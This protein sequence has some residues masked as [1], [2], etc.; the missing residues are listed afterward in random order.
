MHL[1][2]R[3]SGLLGPTPRSLDPSLLYSWTQLRRLLHTVSLLP[4]PPSNCR[5]RSSSNASCAAVPQPTDTA[6]IYYSPSSTSRTSERH[7]GTTAPRARLQSA[8]QP[9]PGLENY[10]QLCASH[11]IPVKA[12]PVRPRLRTSTSVPSLQ[13]HVCTTH[14][15]TPP[16]R[17]SATYKRSASTAL[18]GTNHA[19][20][21]DSRAG[22]GPFPKPRALVLPRV[23]FGQ[24][25]PDGLGHIDTADSDLMHRQ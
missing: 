4:M 17:L 3:H 9:P 13:P 14:V 16:V 11:G 20:G 15:G 21:A 8:P 24:A 5:S 10:A 25:T 22:R 23:K 7:E 12:A 19:I 18:A 6:T 1:P 2:R